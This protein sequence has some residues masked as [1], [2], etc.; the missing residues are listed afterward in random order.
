MTIEWTL[1][2]DGRISAPEG[3]LLEYKRDLSS[4]DQALTSIIAF[5]NSAG[6]LLV[7]GVADDRTVVGVADPLLEEERLSNLISDTIRPQLMPSIELLPV[8]NKTILVARISLGSQ[9]PYHLKKAG[10]YDGT[11]VRVGSSDRRAG[12]AHGCSALVS[13]DHANAA[14]PIRPTSTGRC[15]SLSKR[16]W[17]SS[18][19]THSC[20]PS[21]A[22]S[23][24]D[25]GRTFLNS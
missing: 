12:P 3:K 17:S 9:P 14:S 24:A 8:G 18:G 11:Y 1:D 20:A 16:S 25:A 4:P 19:G 5:A 23:H 13:A 22:T 10:R 15:R 6:G 2:A 21:S 7:V